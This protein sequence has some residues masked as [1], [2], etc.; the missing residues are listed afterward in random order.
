MTDSRIHRAVSADGTQIAGRV[1][2][3]GPALVLV[4][5]GIGDGEIAWDAMLPHLAD[6][7][8]C[9]LPSTRGRG[10]S[11][12]NPDHSPPRLEEDVTAF[13][14]SIG[15]P[16]YLAGWSGSGTWVLGTAA[17][18]DSVVAAAA[19]EPALMPVMGE[20][21]LVRTFGTMEQMGAAAADGRLDDALRAFAPWICTDEEVAALE[22]TNFFE[23]WAGQVPAMLRF[24][25]HEASYEGPR[26]TDPEVLGRITVPVL[27]LV[28]RQSRL[29]T[30][31]SD[32]AR[33]IAQHVAKPQ[34]WELP[35][36]GHFAP[37]LA[38]ESVA[39]ELVTFFESARQ[40][41]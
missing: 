26:A 15:E 4:H 6:R 18:T 20:D 30:F 17:S 21:D 13:V 2:G 32:S 29:G 40:P 24:V 5:G 41:A 25:Q 31:F 34:T 7:F 23:R 16:V 36:V 3:D 35:G 9:Y 28:G 1:E 38:P 22:L 37:M 14:D 10:L 8:T 11:G 27:L 19:Y 12:D 33:F 39:E